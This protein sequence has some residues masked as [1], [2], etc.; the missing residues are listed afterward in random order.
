MRIAAVPVL[1]LALAHPS[2]QG[3]SPW[4]WVPPAGG[5]RLELPEPLGGWTREG[6]FQIRLQVG[7][8]PDPMPRRP[9]GEAWWDYWEEEQKAREAAILQRVKE[10]LPQEA[11][12]S[13]SMI[14]L[15]DWHAMDTPEPPRKAAQPREVA[16]LARYAKARA[17]AEAEARQAERA[18][19]RELRVWCNGR[20]SKL[21]VALNQDAGLA[22]E[23]RSGENRLEVMDPA[24]GQRETRTWWYEAPSGPRL[25]VLGQAGTAIVVL[26]PGGQLSRPTDRFLRTSPAAGTY[27][28][29]WGGYQATS[30]WWWRPEEAAPILAVVDVLIDGG[31]DRERHLHFEQ[32]CLPGAGA[33]LLG[34]FH[35]EE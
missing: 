10:L 1:L 5:G 28:V 32:L 21:D 20:S 4:F 26:E 8:D 18:R 12:S 14:H 22:V 24:T 3:Q 11:P 29:S 15:L 2:A 9:Q 35:V 27:S 30:H 23:P 6:P 19:T 31:T 16:F 13:W 33:V 34:T 17:Q 7:L 25:Q